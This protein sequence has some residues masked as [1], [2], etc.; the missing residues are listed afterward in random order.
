MNIF[1]RQ[2]KTGETVFPGSIFKKRNGPP[3]AHGEMEVR[4]ARGLGRLAEEMW[5]K[6]ASYKLAGSPSKTILIC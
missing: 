5:G 1:T 6:C 3:A 4:A 2:R